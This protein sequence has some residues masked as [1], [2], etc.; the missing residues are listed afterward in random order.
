MFN[1]VIRVGGGKPLELE[2]QMS[3][4][5]EDIFE[6]E[7]SQTG[8]EELFMRIMEKAASLSDHPKIC[9]HWWNP[10][11]CNIPPFEVPSDRVR[12]RCKR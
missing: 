4:T 9:T 1:E 6:T 2:I 8:Q 12:R 11:Y 7:Y 5:T 10:T 3:V